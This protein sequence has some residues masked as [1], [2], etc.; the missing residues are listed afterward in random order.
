MDFPTVMTKWQLHHGNPCRCQMNQFSAG[1]IKCMQNVFTS[2]NPCLILAPTTS[3]SS[4]QYKLD[5]PEGMDS[6]SKSWLQWPSIHTSL[7]KCWKIDEDNMPPLHGIGQEKVPPSPPWRMDTVYQMYC[8]WI[9][10]LCPDGCLMNQLD[11]N[12]NPRVALLLKIQWLKLTF[13]WSQLINSL[14]GP[15]HLQTYQWIS[16]PVPDDKTNHQLQYYSYSNDLLSSSAICSL[17][18]KT[19]L[20]LNL[21]VRIDKPIAIC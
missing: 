19:T 18:G 1:T 17:H 11:T 16:L 8:F 15:S 12:T 10:W 20:W 2:N 7:P 13:S 9:W 21:Q 5:V 14:K 3:E 6:I 4:R